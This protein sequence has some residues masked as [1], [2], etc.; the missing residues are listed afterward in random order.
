[1][2]NTYFKFKHFT[3]FQ[4]RCAMK[5]TTLACIQ[6]A[7]LPA[8]WPG[9]I[10]D[11]GAGTGL[12]SM[13]VAQHLEGHIDAV[14]IEDN[15]Y[16]QLNQNISQ[17]PWRD[18]ITTHHDDIRH[19]AKLNSKAYD[20]IITNPPFYQNQFKTDN[21]K[22]NQARHD[23]GLTTS[24]L[25]N[26]ISKL[27]SDKGIVSVL[28]PLPESQAFTVKASASMLFPFKQLLIKDSPKKPVKAVVTL[29]SKSLRENLQM[30]ICIKNERNELSYDYKKLLR[31]YYL[32]L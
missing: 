7:W 26:C 28:L 27:L 2:P 8:I 1:L 24:D 9:M 25:V 21:H 31:P 17:C 14:E 15:A 6:G 30:T 3:I 13:M 5:V 23:D 18:R 32:K 11:I 4:D 20:F 19:F 10:L 12:L 29:L 16:L 22:V